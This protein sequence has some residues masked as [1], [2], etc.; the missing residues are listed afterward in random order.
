MRLAVDAQ[1]RV[2]VADEVSRRVLIFDET[3]KYLGGFGQYGTDDHGFTMPGG[4]AVDKDGFVYMG[5]IP[6]R[7]GC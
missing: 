7:G 4:I 2:Y 5:S 3:G 1:S 6:V